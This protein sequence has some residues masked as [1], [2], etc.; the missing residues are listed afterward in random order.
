MAG[1]FRNTK[2]SVLPSSSPQCRQLAAE[3][4]VLPATKIIAQCALL[5]SHPIQRVVQTKAA[6]A[7][8]I[9]GSSKMPG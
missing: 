5:P 2:K 1:R 9:A 4:V 3:S 7:A 8:Q 6:Q